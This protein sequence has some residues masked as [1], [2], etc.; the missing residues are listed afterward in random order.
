MLQLWELMISAKENHMNKDYGLIRTCFEGAI[1]D[2][3]VR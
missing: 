2:E 3:I 1:K